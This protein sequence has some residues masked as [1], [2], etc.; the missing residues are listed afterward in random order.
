MGVLLGNSYAAA[1]GGAADGIKALRGRIGPGAT[2]TI[3]PHD[4]EVAR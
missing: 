2:N 4:E 3:T 1:R